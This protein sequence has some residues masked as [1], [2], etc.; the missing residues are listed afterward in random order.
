MP[1][2]AACRSTE[3][4]SPT[5]STGWWRLHDASTIAAVIVEPISGSAGVL[6]PPVGYLE[7]LRSICDKYGILL[8]FDEVITGFGR[9]GKAFAAQRFGVTPDMITTAKGLSNGS[10]PMGAVLVSD[11][12]HEAFMQGPEACDRPVPWLHLLRPPAGLRGG[13]GGSGHLRRGRPVRE[14]DFAGHGLGG[15]AART[16]RAA[17]RHR[18]PQFRRGRRGRAVA[19]ARTAP[20]RVGYEVFNRCFHDH[21][22]M[23]RVTGRH[24]R[25]FA[26]ADPGPAHIGAIVSRLAE[27]IRADPL[28]GPK[29]IMGG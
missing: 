9:V 3:P 8:I 27:A 6:L 10:V 19:S 7:R 18:H 25:R 14:G 12:V 5:T 2:R 26:A 28:S 22:L 15:R 21:D 1:S 16:A 17:E 4:S 24:H 29:A 13:A 20:G 23:V 11:R